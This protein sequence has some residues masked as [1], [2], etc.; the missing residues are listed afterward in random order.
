MEFF[1]FIQ[2]PEFIQVWAEFKKMRLGKKKPLSESAEK[3]QLNKVQELYSACHKEPKIVI[4]HIQLVTDSFWDNIYRDK[5]HLENILKQGNGSKSI[6]DAIGTGKQ[7]NSN[8]FNFDKGAKYY[9]TAEQLRSITQGFD[10]I[11]R[12]AEG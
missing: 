5:E 12:V 9:D 6:K 10:F 8:Y 2:T 4:E 11:E 1:Q 3:R 7:S